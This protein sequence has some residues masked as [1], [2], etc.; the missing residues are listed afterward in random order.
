[1]GNYSV[2]S[3]PILKYY[4]NTNELDYCEA[5]QPRDLLTLI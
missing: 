5:L 4:Q 1:M 3:V 2:V